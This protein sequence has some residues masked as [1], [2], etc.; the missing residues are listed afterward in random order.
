MYVCAVCMYVCAFHYYVVHAFYYVIMCNDTRGISPFTF[1]LRAAAT[2]ISRKRPKST[3]LKDS[4]FVHAATGND[5]IVSG[6]YKQLL[7]P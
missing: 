3:L 4:P 6:L 7:E 5:R 1:A 2:R